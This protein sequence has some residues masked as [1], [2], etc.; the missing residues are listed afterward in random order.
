[1]SLVV[2]GADGSHTGLSTKKG[3][4]YLHWTDG[5]AEVEELPRRRVRPRSE[6]GVVG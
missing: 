1:M 3:R 5:M 2:L 4:S 6:G